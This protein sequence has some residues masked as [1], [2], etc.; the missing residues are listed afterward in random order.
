MNARSERTRGSVRQASHVRQLKKIRLFATDV[1]GVL[2]DG[3]MYWSDSG[4]QIRKFH[5]W[6]GLGLVLLKNAGIV[7][8]F[9]TMDHAPLVSLRANGLGISEIHQGVRDKLAVL[10]ELSLKYHLGFEEIAYMGDD[11]NDVPALQA[12]G[13]SAAPANGRDQVRSTVRYVCSANGG[14]G[15][16]RE[17]ADMILAVQSVECPTD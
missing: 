14:E 11:V 15:A 10:K 17:V 8:A 13:F 9:I 16:V 1:D 6:D 5:A 4:D 12:V 7:V 3:G 2:T